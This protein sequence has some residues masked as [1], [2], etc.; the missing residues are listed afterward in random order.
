VQG[1]FDLAQSR[2]KA[3]LVIRNIGQL[4]TMQGGSNSP[5]IQPTVKSLGIVR[6]GGTCICGASGRICFVGKET[7]LSEKV[8]TGSA[9]EINA[10]NRL[11]L[12]GFVDS[13]THAIFAGSRENEIQFKISGLSYLEILKRGGGILKT[14]R[15]T[16][17]ASDQDLISQTKN[18]LDRMIACGTTTFEIKTGYG[19][20]LKEETRLLGLIDN[21]KRS[22]GYDIESTLLAAHAMPK[23]FSSKRKFIDEVV[24]PSIDYAAEKKLASFCDV[25]ME[26]GV[27][28]GSDS[29]KILEYAKSRGLKLKI[30][31]DEFSDLGGAKIAS[32]LGVVSADHLLKA[33]TNG[34]KSLGKGGIV[35]VLLPGTSLALFAP[36]YAKARALIQSKAPVAI[37]TDLSP[38]SWVESMQFVISLACYGMKMTPEEALI[39]STINGAH[40]IGRAN[41]VGSLEEGKLCDLLITNLDNYEEIPY[42]IAANSISK[43]IKQGRVIQD[44][45]N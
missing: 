27:F 18:R 45:Q 30:H 16:R 44:N 4:L 5:V 33:S 24:F 21:I 12:P 23:E 43:V 14:V 10:N 39:A 26:R 7:D 13:H 29:K 11:V 41:D 2:I 28:N 36:S 37:A 9:L 25:F 6:G 15:Q 32:Y 8:D 17:S 42:R 35:C 19:L 3:D 38:N 22:P 20:S 34:I 1:N 40:A 31:A